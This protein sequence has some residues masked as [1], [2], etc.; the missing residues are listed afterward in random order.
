MRDGPPLRTSHHP[1]TRGANRYVYL[2]RSRRAGGLSIGVN[3]DPQKTCNF[4]C[5]YC[6][7]IDRRDVA[8]RAGRP[9]IV[10]EDV[11]DELRAVLQEA[12]GT[13]RGV[14][15]RDIAYAGDGEPSTFPGFLGLSR[16]LLDVRD[17][18]GF[19]RLPLV[20][21]TNGSGL[22]RAE[23]REAHDLFA[24]RGGAFWIKLDA[25]TEAFYRAV[26]RTSVPFDRVLANLL[27]AARRH[28]VVVQALF[29]RW[30]GAAPDA[31]ELDAWAARL[32][33]VS[34]AGG[35]IALVQ[36]Y[37]VA[38]D[39]MEPGIEPLTREELEAIARRIGPETPAAVFP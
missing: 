8:R 37:T 34:E 6:E 32:R 36:V 24:A 12:E 3:L 38:R 22:D 16:R 26:C 31:A 11:A 27:S 30:N 28:P 13:G 19:A 20:L 9:A 23:M 25:G 2:V 7:V 4:D 39:T 33:A 10:V 29:F 17:A 15:L 1:R 18:A 5:V 14:E 21:V 35:A